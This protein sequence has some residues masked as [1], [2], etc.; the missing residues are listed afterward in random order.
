MLAQNLDSV[1][2][3]L[4][5]FSARYLQKQEPTKGKDL[6]EQSHISTAKWN[7]HFFDSARD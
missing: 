6:L 4:I 2:G 7:L 5:G 3:S 1:S